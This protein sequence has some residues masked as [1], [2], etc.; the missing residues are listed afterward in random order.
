M[1]GKKSKR[2]EEAQLMKRDLR[3]DLCDI[4]YFKGINRAGR[5]AGLH[6]INGEDSVCPLEEMQG[7]KNRG[8]HLNGQ[9]PGWR[10][11][12]KLSDRMDTHPVILE[13]YIPK[14]GN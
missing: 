8:P 5:T 10:V 7:V 9:N 14:A 13:Q 4:T 11:L 3:P 6:G 2:P 12:L 1:I